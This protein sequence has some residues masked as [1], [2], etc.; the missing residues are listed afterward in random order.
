MPTRL[1]HNRTDIPPLPLFHHLILLAALISHTP[2]PGLPIPLQQH[3]SPSSRLART[4]PPPTYLPF[5]II[6]PPPKE[7]STIPLKPAAY[8]VIMPDPACGFP[9]LDCLA[10]G[11][12]EFVY[13]GVVGAAREVCVGVEAGGPVGR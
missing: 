4:L 9:L 12:A 2:D 11:D 8:V 3:P 6:A 13:S 7:E 1:M 10:A 5:V